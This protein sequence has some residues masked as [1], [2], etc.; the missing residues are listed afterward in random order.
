[1]AVDVFCRLVKQQSSV[2]QLVTKYDSPYFH[3]QIL[4]SH[5]FVVILYAKHLPAYLFVVILYAKHLPAYLFV[6]SLSHNW[7]RLVE[8]HVFA[9]VIGRAFVTD[10][11]KLRIHSKGRSLHV[12][13][14]IGFFSEI[15]EVCPYCVCL[16]G[17]ISKLQLTIHCL[18]TYFHDPAWHMSGF[19]LVICS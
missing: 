5:C 16:Y 10:V 2:A 4:L 19:K 14:I 17:A 12:D 6:N 7:Y 8:A 9:F 18:I 1:L 3:S 11:E 13:D 15:T